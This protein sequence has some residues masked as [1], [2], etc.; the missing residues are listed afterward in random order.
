MKREDIKL[1]VAIN[2]DLIYAEDKLNS[3]GK[4]CIIESVEIKG[5]GFGAKREVVMSNDNLMIEIKSVATVFY[6]NR[7]EELKSK[8]NEL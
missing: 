2:E 8:L 7:I 6:T 5:S 1:A 4:T 3:L